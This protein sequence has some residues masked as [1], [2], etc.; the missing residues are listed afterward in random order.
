MQMP[1]DGF[2][3][4]LLT[5]Q[6]SHETRFPTD[7]SRMMHAR[8]EVP[9]ADRGFRWTDRP[10]PWFFFPVLPIALLAPALLVGC[11]TENVKDAQEQRA[12]ERSVTHQ[13][14]V[15]EARLVYEQ[16]TDQQYIQPEPFPSNQTPSF[17]VVPDDQWS[18]G[19]SISIVVTLIVDVGGKV[20]DVRPRDAHD[21]GER[22]PFFEQVVVA[23]LDWRFTPLKVR[24]TKVVPD[25][26][27]FGQPKVRVVTDVREL[28]FSMG[29]EFL[30]SERG[31]VRGVQRE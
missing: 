4:C 24:T 13:A 22:K 10:T 20:T 31:V 17:P 7:G 6:P 19:K 9:E 1:A 18:S 11:R 30:F 25:G 21:S 16:E 26:E 12:T 5:G 3:L 29:Y 8:P 27:V 23:C 14:L 28:P 2:Q 15:R